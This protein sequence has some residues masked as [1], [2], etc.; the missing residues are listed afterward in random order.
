MRAASVLVDLAR[1]RDVGMIAIKSVAKRPW[2]GP[3]HMHRTWYEPFDRQADIE[4][5][6]WY[7]LSQGVTTAAMPGDLSLWPLVIDA[8][9][10]YRP[11]DEAEQEEVVSEARRYQPIFPQAYLECPL[12][13]GR[14]VGP[15]RCPALREAYRRQRGVV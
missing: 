7:T 8:A 6:L 5:C 2:Q 14:D 4:K 1:Q 13:C 3:M 11:L 12:S 15:G 9:E 10:R